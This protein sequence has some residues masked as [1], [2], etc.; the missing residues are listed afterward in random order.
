MEIVLGRHDRTNKTDGIVMK[1][2][3]MII[4]NDFKSFDEYDHNDIALLKLN[5]SVTFTEDIMP[6]CLPHP[7]KYYT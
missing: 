5:D 1:V 4:H 3:S 2:E 6:I 7:S